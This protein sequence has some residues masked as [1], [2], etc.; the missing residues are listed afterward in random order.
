MEVR[1][2]FP[3]FSLKEEHPFLRLFMNN[4]LY[5]KQG[6]TDR[7]ISERY[8]CGCIYNMEQSSTETWTGLTQVL[9]ES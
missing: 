3:S 4:L 8:A 7:R 6:V 1:V 5:E 2:R 9:N